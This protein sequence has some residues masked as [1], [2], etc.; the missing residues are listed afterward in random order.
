[1]KAKQIGV[2]GATDVFAFGHTSPLDIGALR[3]D[4][5]RDT[6][7][8]EYTSLGSELFAFVVTAEGIEV[9][10][11]LAS[12]EQVDGRSHSSVFRSAACVTGR[13]R[14]A[15]IWGRW[16]RERVTI[17]DG[18]TTFCSGGSKKIRAWS[19]KTATPG[20]SSLCRT[21]RCTTFRFTRFT[22]A[23][24]TASSGARFRVRRARACAGTASA[25]PP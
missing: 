17:S 18:S 10:R 22:T 1:M 21:A 14:Y 7:L 25:A 2:P 15:R 23:R 20:V 19:K 13:A 11:N 9:V 8:I 4:L 16:P 3:R 6:A 12:A 5:G 24:L